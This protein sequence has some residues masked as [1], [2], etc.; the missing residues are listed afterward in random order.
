M[1][2]VDDAAL[3]DELPP[4]NLA[5][6][7]RRTKGNSQLLH[8]LM[9]MFH[10]DFNNASE[11][12]QQLIVDGDYEEAQRLA[13]KLKGA[14]LLLEIEELP[15]IAE[16]T[17]QAIESRNAGKINLYLKTLDAVLKPAIWAAASLLPSLP[18]SKI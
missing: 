15:N 16:A 6:A 5:A 18:P 13:H 8:K 7:L 1:Q 11:K 2:T 9:L 4:F 17:E 12:L 3:P 10:A 14:A